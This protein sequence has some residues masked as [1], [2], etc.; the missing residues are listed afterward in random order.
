MLKIV[1][2]ALALLTGAAFLVVWVSNFSG[3]QSVQPSHYQSSKET[4]AEYCGDNYPDSWGKRLRCDPVAGFTGL[5]ALFTAILAA[6]AW[7]EILYLR[8]AETKADE[9]SDI[10][11][12]QMLIT[13][14]QTDI[15]EKQHAVGRMQFISTHRPILRVRYFRII[16]TS[17][18]QAIIRFTIVNIG[19]SDARLISSL[20]LA[21]FFPYN[22]QPVPVYLGGGEVI[23]APKAMPP[24]ATE[25]GAILLSK[26]TPDIVS[27]MWNEQRA[28]HAYGHISYVDILENV[29]TTAFC[30]R[31]VVGR[32]RFE[33]VND[34]DY[35]YE[36]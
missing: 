2:Q 26:Q 6:V 31:Y 7:I 11:Q 9:I 30:R 33:A 22:G 17:N 20:G 18:K 21:Q 5:L 35:E 14:R 27:E 15:I 4:S 25:E 16:N 12:K 23:E 32:E 19:G 34:P 1:Y 3:P 8:R 28:L 13:G 29:R 36:D 24:G 10:T